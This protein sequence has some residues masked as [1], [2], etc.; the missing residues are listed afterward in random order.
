MKIYSVLALIVFV[1]LSL[2][3]PINFIIENPPLEYWLWLVLIAGFF[4]VFTLFIKTS[5]VVRGIAIASFINCFFSAIPYV[6]FSAY[7]LVVASC[8]FYILCTKITNWDMIFKALQCLALF[9]ILIMF[10][11]YIGHDPLLNFGV[12]HMEHFGTMGQHMQMAS[13]GIILTAILIQKNKWYIAVG[14]LIALFC[15]SSWTFLTV[16]IGFMVYIFHKSAQLSAIALVGICAVFAL[17]ATY[18][19]K[20]AENIDSKHGRIAVWERSIELSNQRPAQGWGIGTFKDLF[21]PLS[22]MECTPW[23]NA[24]NF[25]VQMIFEVGYPLTGCLLIAL[26]WLMW[27]LYRANLWLCLSGL[28]MVIFDALVHFPDR[29]LQIVP[30]L[31]IFFAYCQ[32]TLRRYS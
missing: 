15:H 1:I 25:I 14:L 9:N 2:L 5:W 28:S 19:H 8:Y 26:G 24:H 18:D 20:F 16:M 23:R 13:F 6:S 10:M 12:F 4:G 31:I 27:T 21:H 11:Q 22:K 7:V 32:F 17:W 30:L 3:P 29:C